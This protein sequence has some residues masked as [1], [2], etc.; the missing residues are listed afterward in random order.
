MYFHEIP[1]DCDVSLRKTYAL[2]VVT[3]SSAH[4]HKYM[5]VPVSAAQAQSSPDPPARCLSVDELK[6]T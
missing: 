6:T 2:E 1:D 4:Q 5:S 3:H